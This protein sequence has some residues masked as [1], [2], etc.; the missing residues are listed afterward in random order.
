[1][2]SNRGKKLVTAFLAGMF[3][4]HA[5]LFWQ[6]HDKLRV[7]YQD[8]TIFYSAGRIL[9]SGLGPHLYDGDLQ[10]RVQREFASEVYIRQGPLPFN[11][12]AF[13]AA[14]FVPF[15]KLPYFEAYLLWD[16]LNLLVLLALPLLLRRHVRLLQQ[17]GTGFWLF[18]AL[19]FFPVFVVLLQGQ[20]VLLL[21]LL[22][23]LA[24]VAM[25]Q[26]R[27]FAA[28]CWLGLGLFRFHAVL[29]FILILLFRKKGRLLLGFVLVAAALGFASIALLGWHEAITY[30][31]YLWRVENTTGLSSIVPSLM[32]NL[33]GLVDTL[34]PGQAPQVLR[35]A[36]IAI[37]SLAALLLVARLWRSSDRGELLDLGFSLALLATLLASYHA[38]EH[39]LSLL[40]L[41]M[42]LIAS[43]CPPNLPNLRKR[44]MLLAPMLVLFLTPLHMVL[45]FHW[46]MACLLALVLLLWFWGM[47][48][49]ISQ[50]S[51]NLEL[52][53]EGFPA[54]H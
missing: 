54:A 17:A 32:P 34:M 27:D 39:D 4:M 15:A 18:V 1:M 50:Q 22:F 23:A 11:H 26:R 52:P 29:P 43:R 48:R 38:Y 45:F 10:F 41:P 5:V 7:G 30:I 6:L 2:G 35:N 28:G 20:D 31:T 37:L 47:V 3:V 44:W 33:R 49:E 24:Y 46:D 9:A 14:L 8:F 12:P 36:V 19:S 51:R 21:L 42:L 13:E 16:L 53:S 25:K 40:L